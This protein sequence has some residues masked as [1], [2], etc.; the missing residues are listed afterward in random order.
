M[1]HNKATILIVDDEEKTRKILK[2]N[3]SDKYHILLA[4]N[5]EEALH[6][7]QREKVHLVLTDLK[8][9]GMSGLELLQEIQNKYKHI[10][11]IIITAY[12]SIENAVAAMKLG[13]YDYIIKPIK[14]E[15]LNTLLEKSLQYS[16]LLK[17]N[18]Q[19]KE[20]LKQY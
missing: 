8:M 5:G 3:F 18:L 19:L 12:G 20:K 14:I 16:H 10:P 15:K 13:A 9:P 7:L 6:H 1:N 11:V 17:E 2:L 4:K